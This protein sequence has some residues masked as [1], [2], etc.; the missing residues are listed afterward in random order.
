MI[1]KATIPIH[2]VDPTI[3]FGCNDEFIKKI[4]TRFNVTIALRNNALQVKGDEKNVRDA[5][6]MIKQMIGTGETGK[7]DVYKKVSE[8]E[9]NDPSQVTTPKRLVK[10]KTEGQ[11]SYLSAIDNNDIVISIGPA[12][13]GKTYLGV[14]KAVAYLMAH[15]VERIMLTRPAVEA[16]E[17]LGFLPG[18][19]E[20]KVDPY[21]RPLFDALNDF[22]PFDRVKKY[23]AM[24]TIEVAPLAYMRGRTLNDSF[25]ILD[26][27]QNTTS[28]QMKMFLT[29][30]GWRSKVVVT[31]DIT[32]VDLPPNVFSGLIEIQHLL[33]A[34]EGIK[35][36]YLNEKDVVRHHL[37][38]K[39][40]RA[41]E[42]KNTK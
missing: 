22:L 39:M 10:A 36:V 13:T 42:E 38:Q 11:A 32:Q 27:A 30:M 15:K 14:A 25:I 37:V 19:I 41:Y 12:G 4:Q 17:S 20:E 8:V 31:G 6:R 1:V 23:M 28:I 40:I 9:E 24:K 33:K 3:L 16:G 21:L 5:A 26:E 7:D 35:F 34:I 2:D 18:A 29:R